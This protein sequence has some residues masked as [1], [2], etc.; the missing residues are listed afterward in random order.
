MI[1]ALY[2]QIGVEFVTNN[3]EKLDNFVPWQKVVKTEEM[4]QGN[5]ANF[6]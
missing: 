3:L 1:P 4:L 5:T 6:K 2:I